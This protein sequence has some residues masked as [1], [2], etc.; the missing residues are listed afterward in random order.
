MNLKTI[1]TKICVH[2]NECI[3]I[4][5]FEM[6]RYLIVFINSGTTRNVKVQTIYTQRTVN[7][8]LSPFIAKKN[9]IIGVIFLF[10]RIK[11]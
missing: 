10:Y 7:H 11:K 4:Y 6:K 1:Y 5:C 9:D 3:C 2:A 8:A